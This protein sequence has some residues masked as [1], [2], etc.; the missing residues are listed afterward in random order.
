MSDLAFEILRVAVNDARNAQIKSLAVLRRRL[1]SL[2]PDSPQ[3][4]EQAINF[5]ADQS[6][7]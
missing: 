7:P 1:E 2:F 3:D 4:I 6:R 5:W